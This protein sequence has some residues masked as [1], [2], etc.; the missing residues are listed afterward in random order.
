V[1]DAKDRCPDIAGKPEFEGCP[2]AKTLKAIIKAAEQKA[3]LE[4]IAA[5]KQGVKIDESQKIMDVRV[6]PIL[7]ETNSAVIQSVYKATLDNIADLMAKNPSYKIRISGHADNVGPDD[8]NRKLSEKRSKACFDYLQSKGVSATRMALI[9]L[10]EGV[11]AADN[12]TEEGR[13]RNRRVEVEAF[14]Q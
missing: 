10:G 1:E 9:G 11:P 8:Y 12:Q 14:R 13:Q 6:D 3:R 5:K 2:D 4:A 7:F